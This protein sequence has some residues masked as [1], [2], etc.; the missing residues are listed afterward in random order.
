MEVRKAEIDRVFGLEIMPVVVVIPH[1]QV[2][3]TLRNRVPEL[4]MLRRTPD[5]APCCLT[6]EGK[7]QRHDGVEELVPTMSAA[8]PPFRPT[9]GLLVV[10]VV[11]W[12][13][14]GLRTSALR[15]SAK[16]R[17]SKLHHSSKI[18][19]NVNSLAGRNIQ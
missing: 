18:N 16:R 14:E 5:R 4:M 3:P 2:G 15:P 8:R 10:Q 9:Q 17:K 7:V 19:T 12:G 6:A 13:W 1:S 11:V